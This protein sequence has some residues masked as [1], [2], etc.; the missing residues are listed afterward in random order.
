MC[1]SAIDPKTTVLIADDSAFMRASLKR[2]IESDDELR[3]IGTADNG[4]EALAKINSL[5]PDVVTLDI[6]MPGMDGFEILKRVMSDLP[7]PIII[8]S[9]IARGGAKAT[10]EALDLGAFDCVAKSLNYGTEDVMK[11]QEELVSKI[12][13]AAAAGA[14]WDAAIV[15]TTVLATVPAIA[16]AATGH[17][18]TSS[19]S[20]Q[21]HGTGKRAAA[22]SPSIIAIGTS[23]GGPKA[24]QTILSV[25]PESLPV[26]IVIV[27]HMPTG[28]IEPLAARL[29]LLSR[30]EVHEAR[31]GEH[32]QPGHAYLAP[33][34]RHL[35]FLRLNQREV[36]IHL[37]PLPGDLAHIPSINVMMMSAAQVFQSATMGIILSGM[38][39]DGADGMQAIFR[40]GGYTLGQDRA[41]CVVYGMPRAC[42]DRGVLSEMVP[43]TDIAS[44]ILR[45]VGSSSFVTAH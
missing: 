25:M 39:D 6:D 12:K 21:V 19:L 15:P 27:Q 29:N 37:S 42:H 34:G 22:V 18:R 20:R 41:S 23:T 17:S 4:L 7:R 1:A 5:C 28:F 16:A 9:S 35:T 33:T 13:A 2:M 32:L 3:V 26:P 38:G 31:E 10:L 8:V 43:L 36:I 14:R 24:L 40:H 44:R 45:E 30:L 11:V